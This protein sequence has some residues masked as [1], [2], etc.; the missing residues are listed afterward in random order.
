MRNI[1]DTLEVK[2]IVTFTPDELIDRIAD[3]YECGDIDDLIVETATEV[4]GPGAC[5]EC[6]DVFDHVLVDQTGGWC[7]ECGKESIKSLLVLAGVV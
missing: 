1:F 7:D 3:D 5:I 4:D 2:G 6:G